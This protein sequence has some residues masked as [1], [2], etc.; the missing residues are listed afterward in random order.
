MKRIVDIL[1]RAWTPCEVRMSPDGPQVRLHPNPLYR[2]NRTVGKKSS[3]RPVVGYEVYGRH[4]G[5]RTTYDVIPAG[6]FAQIDAR[7][8]REK[9]KGHIR[10]IRKAR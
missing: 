9:L 1:P 7:R 4:K 2:S 3:K 5:K 8:L 10:K 6:L